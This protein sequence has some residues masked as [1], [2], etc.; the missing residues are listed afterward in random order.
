MIHT[1]IRMK[2]PT[3]KIK[4]AVETLNSLAEMIRIR[5]GCISCRIYHDTQEEQV[6]MV[7]EVWRSQDE[8]ERYLRSVD[9]RNV[10]LVVEMAAKE[11][12]ISFSMFSQSTGLETIE[13][14]ISGGKRGEGTY[15]RE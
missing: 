8:L 4:E 3:Q 7:E 12:E 6:I 5:P 11:P 10:L 13:K 1:T 2:L 15:A 14:A 9:Y